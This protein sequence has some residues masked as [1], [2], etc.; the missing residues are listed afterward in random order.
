M[1]QPPLY[2]LHHTHRN[3]PN[4]NAK[5][6]AEWFNAVYSLNRT[7]TAPYESLCCFIIRGDYS[8][9]LAHSSIHLVAD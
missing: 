2:T 8:W 9:Q 5:L 1:L 4:V 6:S 3:T 7:V